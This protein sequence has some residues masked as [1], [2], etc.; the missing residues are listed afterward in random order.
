MTESYSDRI[1]CTDWAPPFTFNALLPCVF[2]GFQKAFPYGQKYSN[3]VRGPRFSMTDIEDEQNQMR[4]AFSLGGYR[5]E[6]PGTPAA[7]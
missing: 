7:E 4:T 6:Q 1:A 3:S 2:L 5:I